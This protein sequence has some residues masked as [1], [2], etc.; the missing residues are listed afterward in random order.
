[1]IA[2]TAAREVGKQWRG[3]GPDFD[4]SWLDVG[5]A[6]FSTTLAAQTAAAESGLAYVP[7]VLGDQDIDAPAVAQVNPERFAGGTRDGRPVESLLH[8]AVYQAKTAVAGGLATREALRQAGGWL[9]DVVMDAVRDANRQAVAA[10]IT[11]R[12]RVQGWVRM[13]N[14]PS[15]KFCVTL[16]GK[17]FRWNQGFQSHPHCDCRHIPSREA[18]AG[19]LTVDPYAY[20]RSLDQT[21][22]DRLWGKADAQAIRDG[23]DM[24]RVVNTRSRGL[25]SDALKNTPGRNRGWQSRKWDTPS[26]MTIDD[27]Y[28]NARNRDDAIRLMSENGFITG[29]QTAGGNLRGN[30]PSEFGDLAA[31]ALGRGGSRKGA[32]AAYREAIR[33]GVR[34]PLEPATQT[35]QE[36]RLHSAHLRM[37]AVRAGRNPFATNTAREPLTPEIRRIIEREYERQRAR[38][39]TA[40]ESVRVLARLLGI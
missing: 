20:F 6:V 1:M 23:G 39:A 16:A 33:S 11:T 24:Y 15:C 31:G 40:P 25:A 35:A 30:T 37:Q 32:T 8:G 29:P 2:V 22:Q 7:A 10:D 28:A 12:P 13:L 3:M 36:R 4:L 27:V 21:T 14:P 19:D 18:V 26:K 34:D 17:F 9:Q 5:E 38:I